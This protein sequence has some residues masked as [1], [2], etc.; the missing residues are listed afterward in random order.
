MTHY[1]LSYTMTIIIL[2]IHATVLTY[3]KITTI[4]SNIILTMLAY[5]NV[6]IKRNGV[7]IKFK[8]RNREHDIV[9]SILYKNLVT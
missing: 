5:Q 8:Y 7:V 3:R 2:N 1:I 4:N 9:L 6:I